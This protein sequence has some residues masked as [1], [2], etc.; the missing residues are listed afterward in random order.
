MIIDDLSEPVVPA[1]LT[2]NRGFKSQRR[3]T[4]GAAEL[5][6][7]FLARTAPLSRALVDRLHLSISYAIRIR[8]YRSIGV[9]SAH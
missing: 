1:V 4:I 2:L 9:A 3:K 7:Q 6:P 5:R 8:L